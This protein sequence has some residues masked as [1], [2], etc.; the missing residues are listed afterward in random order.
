MKR[1]FYGCFSL[2]LIAI[3]MVVIRKPQNNLIPGRMVLYT[4][5]W[6]LILFGIRAI[7]HLLEKLFRQKKW[8]AERLSR[9][10]FIVYMILYG[11]TLYVVSLI[12]RSYPV[13]D[14]GNVYQ[15][16]LSLASGQTVEDWSY[17]SMWTNNLGTLTILAFC[18]RIGYLLGFADPYYFVLALN[19]LQVT[20]VML[21]I[22]YLAG[23]M[24]SKSLA[25]QWFAILV[26]TLWTPVWASTNSFYSDQLSFGGSIIAI[27]LFT[28]AHSRSKKWIY[29]FL[30][31]IIWGISVTA[32]V[33]SAICFIALIIT[34]ILNKKWKNLLPETITLGV[35]LLLAACT[36]S[37]CSRAYP[38]KEDEYRLK[39]PTEYW[40]AMGLVGNGTYADNAYLVENCNYSPNVDARRDFCRKVIRENW[41]NIFDTDHLTAKVSVIF[42]TGEIAP[43][44]LIY[45]YDESFLWQWLYWEGDYFWKYA[46]LSTSFFFAMMFFM[47]AGAVSQAAKAQDNDIVLISFLTVFGIFLFL[48]LWE[49][50]NKQL[51]NHIPWMTL[52]SVFGLESLWNCVI[53]KATERSLR[54]AG[55]R[56]E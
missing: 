36:L 16:A 39:S 48:M 27:A 49:A 28:F 47:L 44:S 50:Q 56:T 26:F 53:L 25:G 21:S 45:P 1:I 19:V 11:I 34:L 38:S 41:T 18:M 46:C 52:A 14:Y 12:L 13:T 6:I 37:L 17:F 9:N 43:T 3:L 10:A 8:N 55:N 15:T 2:G 32:K 42:G 5:V 7:L 30:A 4:F 20:A 24:G 23:K 31:G 29:I 35:F 40:V 22:F 33:T 51:Y 54:H